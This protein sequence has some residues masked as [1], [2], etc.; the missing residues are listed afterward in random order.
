MYLIPYKYRYPYAT[1]LL[2]SDVQQGARKLR[3]FMITIG[4]MCGKTIIG[5]R[6]KHAKGNCREV[7]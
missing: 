4:G 7:H 1:H 6:K 5:K 2:K 3:Q